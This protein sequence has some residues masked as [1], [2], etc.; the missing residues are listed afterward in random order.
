MDVDQKESRESVTASQV[1][2]TPVW[3]KAILRISLQWEGARGGGQALT[4]GNLFEQLCPPPPSPLAV[5]SVF[6]Q[7]LCGAEA[8]AAPSNYCPWSQ[9]PWECTEEL[10]HHYLALLYGS[11]VLFPLHPTLYWK[12]QNACQIPRRKGRRKA[13]S[14][15]SVREVNSHPSAPRFLLSPGAR[16]Q[17]KLCRPRLL[18][19]AQRKVTF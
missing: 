15:G 19:W 12:P 1:C 18:F 11:L 5:C 16:V 10:I 14:C 9:T 17:T 6:S 8:T 3:E 7:G 13:K 2:R 4:R